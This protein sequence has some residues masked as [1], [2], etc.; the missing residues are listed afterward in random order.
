VARGRAA[1]LRLM[2]LRRVVWVEAIAFLIY[3]L[4]QPVVLFADAQRD[5]AYF[6]RSAESIMAGHWLGPYN[7]VTLIKGPAFTYFLVL[8]KFVGLPVTASLAL[9]QIAA[10]LAIAWALFR[11]LK[12]SQGWLLLTFTVL[13]W[14]PGVVPTRVIRD[15]FVPQ[16]LILAIAVLIA[17][18]F[19]RTRTRTMLLALPAGLLIGLFW[20]A[21]EDSVWVVPGVLLLMIVGGWGV[22]RRGRAQWARAAICIGVVIG[23]AA[24]PELATAAMNA[25]Q[26]GVFPVINYTGA[27][28]QDALSQ[29][30]RIEVG[31]EI[32][33][34]PV[35]HEALEAAY[36]ASPALAD[37]KPYL[38]KTTPWWAAHACDPAQGPCVDIRG[39][40]FPWALREAAESAGHF[41]SLSETKRYFTQVADEI[42]RACGHAFK[43]RGKSFGMLPVLT[44]EDLRMLPDALWRSVEITAY[45]LP[46][47]YP[48]ASTGTPAQR[49]AMSRTVGRPF[50][51]P[52]A[53]QGFTGHEGWVELR[54]KAA[55][56]Y[57]I[58][59]PVLA[60][61]GLVGLA[62][63]LV[64]WRGNRHRKLTWIAIAFYG[65]Y[66]SRILL[67]ALAE[68]TSFSAARPQYLGPAYLLLDLGCLVSL[69]VAVDV[70]GSWRRRG[71][72]TALQGS[73][74]E[75]E[76][77]L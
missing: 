69:A 74:S 15:A 60:V 30:D 76:V 57:R 18:L 68:A 39:G 22:W 63:T 19:A 48:S 8:N 70:V 43:C 77:T 6:S 62:V 16:L 21:R 42:G 29:L 10:A 35:S 5:D 49:D 20:I 37:L 67:I 38:D 44:H 41:S 4:H 45:Q 27:S 34:V 64:G 54:A 72:H 17:A 23:A 47:E 24:V 52:T 36:A 55:D 13:L 65:M 33:R 26:Y 59:T 1:L 61:L 11:V 12:P 9:L 31:P 50:A 40:W 73:P 46:V 66:A 28:F 25:K 75:E 58:L 51:T 7:D 3:A 53:A 2:T 56:V 14:S 71:E 32:W